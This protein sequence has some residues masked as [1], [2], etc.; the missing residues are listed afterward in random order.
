MTVT[1]YQAKT[2]LSRI[3]QRVVLYRSANLP[4]VHK[5]PFDRV[6]AAEALHRDVRVVSPDG[7]FGRYGCE[8]VW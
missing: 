3:L 1:V 4:S 6:I 8:V 5:D 2:H 7:P